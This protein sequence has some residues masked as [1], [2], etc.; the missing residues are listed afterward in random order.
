M[1]KKKQ[2]PWHLNRQELIR[3]HKPSI[4]FCGDDLDKINEIFV[5]GWIANGKNVETLEN[6]F[7]KLFDVKFAIACG[8]CT[9]GLV[10]ALRAAGWQH[11]RIA[12]PAFTW[13][14][15]IFAIESNMGNKPVFCDINPKTWLTDIDHLDP[16]SYD[17]ILAVDTFGNEFV[18]NCNKPLI[19]DSAHGFGLK[20][21]GHRGIV[22]VVSLSFNKIVTSIEG[23][24]I[25]TNDQTI[26]KEAIELRRLTSRLEEINAVVGIKSVRN[27]D[28][29]QES[30][31]LIIQNYLNLL[32]FEYEQQYTTASTNQSIFS[33]LVRN[34]KIRNNML[35]TLMNYGFEVKIYYEP[36]I[37]G[38]EI[39]D[40]VYSRILSLP[41]YPEIL[42]YQNKIC[43]LLNEAANMI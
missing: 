9:Q 42:P 4:N 38:L 22:E 8:N 11:K 6:C 35:T 7:K 18:N 15:T 29:I 25:L 39:T 21:L 41:T 1:V 20:N 13:P 34:N 16:S 5:S 37:N 27:F 32:D 26:A 3:F 17:A 40:D 19:I 31:S 23:G 12:V 10:I 36:L 24:M 43:C 30:R 28:K 2:S 33:I 14:S